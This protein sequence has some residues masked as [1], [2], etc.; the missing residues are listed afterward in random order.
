MGGRLQLMK[1]IALL[2][3]S[4]PESTTR[5]FR[6]ND[7]IEITSAQEITQDVNVALIFGGDGTVHRHLPRLH[8][9]RIPFLVVPKGSGNDFARALGIRSEKAA[10]RAWKEFCAGGNNVREIDLGI[11]T[12]DQ[13]EIL[14]CCV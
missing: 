4:V 13:Q 14:F 1:V 7:S 8:A 5:R 6:L 9:R 11:I 12:K 3:P 2:H 10:L